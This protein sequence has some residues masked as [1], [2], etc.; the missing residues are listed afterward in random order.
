MFGLIG[1]IINWVLGTGIG[2]LKD[3]YIKSQDT[4]AKQDEIRA[5]V[6]GKQLDNALESQRVASTVRLATAHHPEMRFLTFIIA[7]A[8]TLHYS[9]V[10]LDT[11]LT[12][13]RLDIPALP[14]PMDEWEGYIVLSFFG[15]QAGMSAIRTAATAF[16][17]RR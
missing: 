6:I 3:A 13:V 9:L 5:Q 12:G 1:G 11:V 17:A 15:L 8:T 2:H 14:P 7:G 10:V 4:K 16:L